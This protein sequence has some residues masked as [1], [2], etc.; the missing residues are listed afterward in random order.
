MFVPLVLLCEYKALEPST[1]NQSF[2]IKTD[3]RD[4]EKIAQQLGVLTEES[5]GIFKSTWQ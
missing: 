4:P 5:Q 1:E 3:V 2:R